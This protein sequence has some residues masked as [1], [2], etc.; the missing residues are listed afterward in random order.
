MT[1]IFSDKLERKMLHSEVGQTN[2]TLSGTLPYLL[3][4]FQSATEPKNAIYA[5]IASHMMHA[6]KHPGGVKHSEGC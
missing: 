1:A 5:L 3:L 2:K 6:D 4:T